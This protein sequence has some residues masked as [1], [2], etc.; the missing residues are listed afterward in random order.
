[1]DTLFQFVD[2]QLFASLIELKDK[3]NHEF[4]DFKTYEEMYMNVRE[5]VDLCHRDGVI[6]D[7]VAI[8]PEK[9][10]I[11]DNGLIPMLKRYKDAGIK[12]FLLTNSHWEYTSVAMNYLFHGRKVEA[13]LK[14]MDEWMDLFD[15]VVVGSC[16]PAYMVDP[17]L[18]LYRVNPKDGSLLNT[19]GVFEIQA[20]G[21]HGNGAELFLQKGK[22]F[23]GGNW[24][25]LHAMLEIEAGEE[26]LYVGDHLYSDVLR[27]KRTLG[28]RSVF[29]MPELED[30]M[31][32]FDANKHILKQIV[33]LRNL[34][35]EL[36][37]YHD[38][39]Q[40]TGGAGASN[41]LKIIEEDD[42]TIKR[43]L[44]DLAEQWHSAFHPV[45]GAMFNAGYQDSR[46]A[47]FVQNY[48]CLYTSRATNLGLSF[49]SRSFRTTT[50]ML[51]HDKMIADVETEFVEFDPW[52]DQI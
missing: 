31:R 27:S 9:Y 41:I 45:W 18:N 33:Q 21:R 47:F 24:K 51:P 12:V 50:E 48:A 15:L 28:W 23:Q 37:G 3:G 11:L 5:C 30:E 20:L 8:N 14:S 6:K 2:A 44:T 19:D 35:D 13:Q 49:A 43:T 1:M 22:V 4:L 34:R 29:I 17:Y 10:I 25:H 42:A 16:K 7:E 40:L 32:V 52:A 38:S 46:F 39:V 26:I 36:S